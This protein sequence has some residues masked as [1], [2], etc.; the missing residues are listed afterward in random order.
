MIMDLSFTKSIYLHLGKKKIF[1]SKISKEFLL[2]CGVSPHFI[3]LF[4]FELNKYLSEMTEG[5][6]ILFGVCK[7]LDDMQKFLPALQIHAYSF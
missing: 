2:D 5:K 3:Y 7:L 4:I 6:L 1:H